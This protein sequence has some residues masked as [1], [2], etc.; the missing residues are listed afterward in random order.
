LKS[1]EDSDTFDVEAN[2]VHVK[3]P[4]AFSQRELV[5]RA[6]ANDN[7]IEVSYNQNLIYQIY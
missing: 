5:A 6:F 3:N 4:V 2:F 1:V 7:V